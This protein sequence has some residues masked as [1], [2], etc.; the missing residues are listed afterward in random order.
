[1]IRIIFQVIFSVRLGRAFCASHVYVLR[2]SFPFFFFLF[3]FNPWLLTFLSWTV[4]ALLTRLTNFTVQQLF[5]Q[6]L[7][8]RYYLHIVKKSLQCFQFSTVSKRTL[9]SFPMHST[10][11]EQGQGLPKNPTPPDPT[12]PDR[13]WAGLRIFGSGFGSSLRV[14]F[15]FKSVSGHISTLVWTQFF[16]F[17][18]I[19]TLLLFSPPPWALCLPHSLYTVLHFSAICCSLFEQEQKPSW[20][21]VVSN[22][23]I[24]LYTARY[25]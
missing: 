2:F 14:S 20:S 9:N 24:C 5:Q 17:E 18:T 15:R 12:R 23:N 10:R 16:S 25:V 7:V 6:K 4:H 8:P 22:H 19:P 21:F 11:T 13:V 1:M 3:F